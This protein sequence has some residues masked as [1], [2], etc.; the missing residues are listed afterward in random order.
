M[1]SQQQLWFPLSTSWGYNEKVIRSGSEGAFVHLSIMMLSKLRS[2]HPDGRLSQILWKSGIILAAIPAL[3]GAFSERKI[4]IGMS[5]VVQE[6]L[7]ELFTEDGQ[8][9]FRPHD[10]E[11]YNV[12]MKRQMYKE[13]KRPPLKT[14][15]KSSR[16]NRQ[17][18]LANKLEENAD[19]SRLH[20][21]TEQVKPTSGGVS[22]TKS[23]NNDELQVDKTHDNEQ[24]VQDT[25]GQVVEFGR[26]S[27]AEKIIPL[28]Q[29][30]WPDLTSI[31]AEQYFMR[32]R[33]ASREMDT[34]T[35]EEVIRKA[36]TKW[37]PTRTIYEGSGIGAWIVRE[38]DMFKRT[39]KID[40]ERAA[41][42]ASK[43]GGSMGGT[44]G[45]PNVHAGLKRLEEHLKQGA[46]LGMQAV[47]AVV[48]EAVEDGIELP[49][50]AQI[51]IDK[52]SKS[53]A[54]ELG[55]G[56]KLISSYRDSGT[57]REIIA[58]PPPPMTK[59][60]RAAHIA[61]A[62]KAVGLSHRSQEEVEE[63]VR[64]EKSTDGAIVMDDETRRI[65]EKA[66]DRDRSRVV[67]NDGVDPIGDILDS[68]MGA[69]SEGK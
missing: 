31:S 6:G 69:K 20:N 67:V 60:E 53:G 55:N 42:A 2:E 17:E 66:R 12:A 10:W 19:F 35:L 15:Q 43:Q 50:I 45:K 64:K 26:S 24:Q 14:F 61:K 4:K 21:S 58:P 52:G 37:P 8:N 13:D 41:I 38:I 59:E 51:W 44:S 56:R 48:N 11:D 29:D 1:T 54:F 25:N 30:L 34:A 65:L 49:N 22:S 68:A 36:W 27:A 3:N 16:K 62:K 7:V 5:K 47:I 32:I 40:S 46:P 23:N 28:L 57:P 39:K 9:Y 63:I 18:S 33:E